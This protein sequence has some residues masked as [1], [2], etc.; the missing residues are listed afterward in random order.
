MNIKITEKHAPHGWVVHMDD[1]DVGFMS[2]KAA[3]E[4][5]EV[6]EARINAP[7]EWPNAFAQPLPARPVTARRISVSVECSP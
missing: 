5:V 3:Q 1:W 2:L 7:H 6:L 4:F